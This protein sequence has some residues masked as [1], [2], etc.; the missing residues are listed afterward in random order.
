LGNPSW[1]Q[2]MQDQAHYRL[3]S[4]AQMLGISRHLLTRLC[5]EGRC[6]CSVTPGRGVYVMNQSQIDELVKYME[7]AARDTSPAEATA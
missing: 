1:S 3:K 7:E 6:R 5:R 2:H 4:V